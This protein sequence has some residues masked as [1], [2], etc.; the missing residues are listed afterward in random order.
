MGENII[1]ETPSILTSRTKIPILP[2]H[3]LMH[4]QSTGTEAA[5]CRSRDLLVIRNQPQ[6]CGLMRNFNDFVSRDHGY[7]YEHQISSGSSWDPCFSNIR[8]VRD[9]NLNQSCLP[10]SESQSVIW[11]RYRLRKCQLRANWVL[12]WWVRGG[13]QLSQRHQNSMRGFGGAFGESIN[14]W[15]RACPVSWFPTTIT[16]WKSWLTSD[17]LSDGVAELSR[18]K[19]TVKSLKK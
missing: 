15:P 9:I 11:S 6:S 4:C 18:V 3:L 7:S 14:R 1:A 17:L 12:G 10:T 2:R 13:Q 16:T 19:T 5:A 8:G